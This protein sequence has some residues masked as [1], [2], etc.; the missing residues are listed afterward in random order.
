MS[1]RVLQ[2]VLTKLSGNVKPTY[3]IW[4]HFY[5]SSDLLGEISFKEAQ[6]SEE[7][8]KTGVS[9][10]NDLQSK[11][12]NQ[13]SDPGIEKPSIIRTPPYRTSVSDPAKHKNI[14][15]GRFYTIPSDDVKHILPK[16]KKNDINLRKQIQTFQEACIMVRKPA[17]EAIDLIQN[18]INYDLPAPKIMLYGEDGAG[19]SYSLFHVIHHC[20][21]Q[22][23]MILHIP[24]P[25]AWLKRYKEMSLSSYKTDRIDLPNEAKDWLEYFA[26]M[27]THIVKD[28]KTNHSYTWSKRE[29]TE[30]GAS[31]HNLVDFGINR[32]NFSNDCVGA[33]LKEIRYQLSQDKLKVLLVIDGVNAFWNEFVVRSKTGKTVFPARKVSLIHHFLKF[34]TSGSKNSVCLCTVDANVNP[35]EERSIHTPLQL[36][37]KEGFEELEPFIPIEVVNYSDDEIHSCFDYYVDR[38]WIQNE[39]A[40]TREGKNQLIALS[41]NNPAEFSKVCASC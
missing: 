25:F 40:K 17:L 23:W 39:M 19:K 34:L 1:F 13:A 7:D 26:L 18:H 33:V 29:S 8:I 4:R 5:A 6:K 38:L 14:D 10:R 35:A 30:A 15:A 20:Y 11:P 16:Q 3:C 27:N 36:L 31:L 9:Y 24:W 2:R 41:N 12:R 32:L 22:N 21:N 37:G 28:V